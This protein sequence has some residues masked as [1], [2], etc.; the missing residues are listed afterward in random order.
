MSPCPKK[1]QWTDFECKLP[2][3][4]DGTSERVLL[5][6]QVRLRPLACR[7]EVLQN[8]WQQAFAA[9]GHHEEVCGEG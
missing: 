4:E 5:I 2:T 3:V 8:S 7:D 9:G 1:T 6:L